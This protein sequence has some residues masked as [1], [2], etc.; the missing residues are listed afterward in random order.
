MNVCD[1]VESCGAC[2]RSCTSGDRPIGT[3]CFEGECYCG[4]GFDQCTGDSVCTD[5]GDPIGCGCSNL[6]ADPRNC[7]A[8]GV[9]CEGETPSCCG[10]ECRQCCSDE[11][12]GGS[13]PCCVGVCCSG[14]D[15]CIEEKCQ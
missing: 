4:E 10:G 8:C 6:D 5:V 9:I 12:C 15:T 1:D 11:E 2:R 7:G 13:H 3:R 14:N